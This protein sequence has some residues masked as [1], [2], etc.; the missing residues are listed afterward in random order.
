MTDFTS[1]YILTDTVLEDY[2]GSSPIPAAIALKALAAATQMWYCQRA[3]KNIDN[4]P[5]KGY[6]YA[7]KITQPREF[8]RIPDRAA[9]MIPFDSEI[10]FQ[11]EEDY[12]TVPQE[13][14]DACC[15]EAIALYAFYADSDNIDRKAMIDQG[16]QSYNLGGIY[17]ESLGTSTR[18]RGRG[19]F[20]P[21]AK[22][23]LKDWISGVTE[24]V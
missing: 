13:V 14:I 2:I 9:Q 1:S 7:D 10:N 5:L 20:S 22:I 17:S 16:V 21:E 19:L 18:D 4:L 23:L 8:P 3:T 24:A 6:R 15:E 12:S 11:S